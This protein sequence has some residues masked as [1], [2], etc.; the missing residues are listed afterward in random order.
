MQAAGT[1]GNKEIKTDFTATPKSTLQKSLSNL[2][3]GFNLKVKPEFL[4]LTWKRLSFLFTSTQPSHC[5][6]LN[7]PKP[8]GKRLNSQ[9]RREK[10]S[11]PNRSS[12]CRALS[13]L[14]TLFGSS[15]GTGGADRTIP[16]SLHKPQTDAGG[17]STS[18]KQTQQKQPEISLGKESLWLKTCYKKHKAKSQWSIRKHFKI[19]L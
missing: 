6:G 8:Q 1:G 10:S 11:T 18:T 12:L 14:L 3:V 2:K 17:S 15:G 13:E 4:D 19:T 9:G 5:Q 7:A 16:C